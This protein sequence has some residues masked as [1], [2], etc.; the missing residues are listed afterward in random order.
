MNKI[1]LHR[2][3]RILIE[4]HKDFVNE[5][6]CKE[7]FTQNSNRFLC[8]LLSHKFKKENNGKIM[9]GAYAE[10]D[11]KADLEYM[12]IKKDIYNRLEKLNRIAFEDDEYRIGF[13]R[14]MTLNL[15]E[16]IN[17]WR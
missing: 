6:H 8:V 12:S 5:D 10:F 1:N 11:E 14:T 9:Y 7:V 4:L 3:L 13:L 17:R 15:K 2:K 16:E